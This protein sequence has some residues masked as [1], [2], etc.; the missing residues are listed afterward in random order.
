MPRTPSISVIVTVRNEA[1]TI[2]SLLESL[3]LQTIA[4]AEVVITDAQSSDGTLEI[5]REFAKK[6]TN[7]KIVS[8]SIPGN[9]SIGRNAAIELATSELIAITDSGCLPKITW[10][11]E[12]LKAYQQWK[13]DHPKST[14]QPV[15]AGY[16]VGV[17]ESPFQEAVIP[18]FLVMPDR[19]N[20]ETYLPATRSMLLPKETWKNVGKFQ[21][22]FNTSEDYIFAHQLVNHQ[23]PIVFAQEAK[24]EW[25]PPT[26]L[27]QVLRSFTSFAECDARAGILR[28][29]VVLLFARYIL[30]LLF[31]I[32]GTAIFPTH[33]L[34]GIIG[35]TI[36]GYSFWSIR[37]NVRY[38]PSGWYWLPVLQLSADLSV[39]V[40]TVSG[41]F[42][43]YLHKRV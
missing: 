39:M 5:I 24:V 10:I 36:L 9:R 33:Y 31:V 2:Q 4:P 19:V 18:Y 25:S 21:E 15:V 16:A 14:E 38:A 40:G 27:R 41:V 12:L 37:K 42:Q 43:R 22:K 1:K 3:V 29:K 26:S 8:R 32:F 28:P 7:I 20:P 6:N 23:T 35:A 34:V 17:A 30:G 13:F 11:E